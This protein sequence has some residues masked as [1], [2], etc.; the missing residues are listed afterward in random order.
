LTHTIDTRCLDVDSS[1]DAK[2][3][4]VQVMATAPCGS[5]I[6]CRV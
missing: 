3:A 2:D 5:V 1:S 6:W 4:F